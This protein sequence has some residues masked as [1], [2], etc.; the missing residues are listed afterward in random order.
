MS[1][2]Q[3]HD[4]SNLRSRTSINIASGGVG[5]LDDLKKRFDPDDINNPQ[6]VKHFIL[7]VKMVA[8]VNRSIVK[9]HKEFITS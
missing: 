6:E 9:C 7:P 4:F 1:H 3:K 5:D 8:T 2:T